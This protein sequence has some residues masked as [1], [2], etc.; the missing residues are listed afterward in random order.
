M[1]IITFR[2]ELNKYDHGHILA[3]QVPIQSSDI[4]NSM[5]IHHSDTLSSNSPPPPIPPRISKNITKISLEQ[6]C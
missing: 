6:Q 1:R 5:N 2:P 3:Q 4:L